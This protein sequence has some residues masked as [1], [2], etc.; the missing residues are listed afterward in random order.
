MSGLLALCRSLSIQRKAS[1]SAQYKKTD[2]AYGWQLRKIFF[3]EF[4]GPALLEQMVSAAGRFT[5]AFLFFF[6][7]KP[8]HFILNVS[9]TFAK[10]AF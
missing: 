2:I 6:P 3:M 10:K 7:L 4:S 5:M 1:A 9:A 8:N